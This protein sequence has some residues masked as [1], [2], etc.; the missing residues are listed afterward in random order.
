MIY[1]GYILIA[2]LVFSIYT[3][4]PEGCCYKIKNILFKWDYIHWTN[5]VDEGISRIRID[6]EGNPYYYRYFETKVI[7]KPG[8]N[9]EIWLT[10]KREKYLGE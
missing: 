10:C 9:R 4:L 3:L 8:D 6:G 2:G 5:G 7:D 1:T